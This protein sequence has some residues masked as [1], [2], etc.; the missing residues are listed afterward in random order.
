MTFPG[1]HSTLTARLDRLVHD[2]GGGVKLVVDGDLA[3]AGSSWHLHAE[4]T[5]FVRDVVHG[6]VP[7]EGMSKFGADSGM[8]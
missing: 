1:A 4:E 2:R 7:Y 6:S 5:T 8:R 3:A